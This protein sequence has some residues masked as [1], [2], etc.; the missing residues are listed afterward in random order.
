M[1]AALRDQDWGEEVASEDGSVPVTRL[2]TWGPIPV[3]PS[4]AVSGMRAEVGGGGP[5]G[6][7][8]VGR[9]G[10]TREAGAQGH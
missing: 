1:V 9:P 7:I 6:V 10:R 5:A 8:G 3:K 2:Q 4:S